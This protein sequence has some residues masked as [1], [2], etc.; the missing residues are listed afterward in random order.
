MEKQSDWT[1]TCSRC[2]STALEHGILRT[3]GSSF[4][5]GVPEGHTFIRVRGVGE[6]KVQRALCLD[7]GNVELYV[8]PD[9]QKV[10]V[11]RIVTQLFAEFEKWPRKDKISL[12]RLAEKVGT[13]RAMIQE[14]LDEIRA[15]YP[16]FALETINGEL[17]FVKR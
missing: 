1:D 3:S 2:G 8:K 11:E 15:A 6:V 7:C 14:L 10:R 13:R 5:Q 9:I 16:K 12:R 17:Y 4:P